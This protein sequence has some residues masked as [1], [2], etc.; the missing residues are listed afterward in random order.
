MSTNR[1]RIGLCFDVNNYRIFRR[2]M[3]LRFFFVA[4]WPN[5]GHGLLVHEVSRSHTSTHQ[6]RYDS[7]GRV[8]SSS[9]RPLPDNTHNTHKK[10]TSTSPAGF[11]PTISADEWPQTI[12]LESA[13]TWTGELTIITH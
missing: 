5:A 7:S 4:L 6:I 1:E 2:E 9:Q 12:A 3:N 13:A 11:K 8:I 10:Q